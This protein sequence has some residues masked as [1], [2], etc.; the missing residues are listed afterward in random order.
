[1]NLSETRIY[2]LGE[3]SVGKGTS[4]RGL[5]GEKP[6]SGNASADVNKLALESG[7][8]ASKMWR[9]M[10]KAGS[11]CV[12]LS[13]ALTVIIRVIGTAPKRKSE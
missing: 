10:A 3:R 12:R 5:G 6:N 1:M 11:L 13:T 9:F 8:Q 2:R 7:A 4:I